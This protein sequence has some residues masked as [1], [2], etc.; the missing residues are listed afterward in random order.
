MTERTHILTLKNP[1]LNAV[2]LT[3][4]QAEHTKKE[5]NNKAHLICLKI[6]SS[7]YEP[8]EMDFP[9]Y[10]ISMLEEIPKPKKLPDYRKEY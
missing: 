3:V 4:E 7:G 2:R 9:W 8:V 6:S 1:K 10:E 5:W